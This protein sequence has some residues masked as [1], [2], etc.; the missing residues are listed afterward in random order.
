MHIQTLNLQ[1]PHAE[2]LIVAGFTSIGPARPHNED[3]LLIYDLTHE[4]PATQYFLQ[5]P[6]D[7]AAL[8]AIA[9][10]IG[11]LN[12]GALASLNAVEALRSTLTSN[13]REPDLIAS[14]SAAQSAIV[15]AM[16]ESELGTTLT[17]ALCR[18]GEVLLGHIGDSRAYLLRHQCLE[19]VTCD[20]TLTR[21]PPSPLT[22]Y[23]GTGADP[24][25]NPD[26]YRFPV[27]SGDRLLL[28]TDGVHGSLDESE[29]LAL[30]LLPDPALA[31][32]ALVEAA[33]KAGSRDN[34]TVILAEWS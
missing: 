28:C 34:M 8:L 13:S 25:P 4:E 21:T 33:E 14:F 22:R 12:Y 32:R 19:Q 23:L 6:A 18:A 27:Q 10:G 24:H 30:A 5:F 15:N 26:L 20:H 11:G 3:A 2:T 29:L 17:A 16:P 1:S 9:D 31:V 7:A